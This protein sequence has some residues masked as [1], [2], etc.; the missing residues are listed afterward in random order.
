MSTMDLFS[1]HAEPEAGHQ[2]ALPQGDAEAILATLTASSG[3]KAALKG[4]SVDE[5][6]QLVSAISVVAA[7]QRAAYA[8][9]HGG[10]DMSASFGW[11]A[12]QPQLGA[13]I[14][15]LNRN[16]ISDLPGAL[17]GLL[18]AQAELPAAG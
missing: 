12:A 13:A 17:D 9:A 11:I 15:V 6:Q 7:H 4:L 5:R 3:R 8:R 18:S 16:F 14:A 1:S 2:D 10:A